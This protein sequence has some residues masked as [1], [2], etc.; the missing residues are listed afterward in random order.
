MSDYLE[1]IS[2]SAAHVDEDRFRHWSSQSQAYAP[3]DVLLNHIRE[4]WTL[5]S[6]VAIETFYYAGFRRIDVFYFTLPLRRNAQTL[7]IPVVANPVV[8]RLI[9]ECGL[10][11]WL[12]PYRGNERY[13]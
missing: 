2:K 4:G 12:H 1:S 10:T 8:T 7:E 9:Q 11:C 13:E 3:A 5:D 6:L